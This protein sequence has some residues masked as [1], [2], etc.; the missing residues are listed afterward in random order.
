[1]HHAQRLVRAIAGLSSEKGQTLAEY[2]FVISII[3]VIVIAT[4]ALVGVGINTALRL[5]HQPLLAQLPGN[6]ADERGVSANHGTPS[7]G[8][9][10]DGRAGELVR[11]L[12][13]PVLVLPLVLL[14]E[15]CC[16]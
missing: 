16:W 14:A 10:L 12:P 13:D 3:V 1:M 2:T 5:G 15:R 9:R 4:L 11:A 7:R 6:A 8:H